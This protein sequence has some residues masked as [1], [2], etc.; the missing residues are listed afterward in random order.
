MDSLAQ[1]GIAIIPDD[2]CQVVVEPSGSSS[3]LSDQGSTT[4][5]QSNLFSR[6]RISSL[7]RTHRKSTPLDEHTVNR[8]RKGQSSR[9]HYSDRYL[10]LFKDTVAEIDSG[11]DGVSPVDP[12]PTQ[13][14]AVNWQ[15]SEKERLLHALAR[16]GRLDEP[17]IATLVGKSELE[18]R[19]Y[20]IFLRGKE[21]ERHLFERQT[22]QISQADI[23]AAVDISEECVSALEQAADALAMYQ[24]QYDLA[25]AEQQH[26]GT[27]LIDWNTAK[28]LDKQVLDQE[29]AGVGLE[30]LPTVEDVPCEGLFRLSSWLELSERL[31]MNSGPPRLDSNWR[32]I[33]TEDERPA[34]TFAAFADFHDLAVSITRRLMQTCMFL[35][36]SR[37]RST[38]SQ[39]HDPKPS[40]KEKDV[41]AA[42]EVLGMTSSLSDK[43]LG[44]ARRN[45][46]RV[47]RGSHDKGSR[48][49]QVLSYEEVEK[50]ISSRQ[51]SRRGRRSVSMASRSSGTPTTADG[52]ISDPEHHDPTSPRVSPSL[53]STETT[54]TDVSRSDV[55]MSDT[56]VY[57]G[58]SPEAVYNGLSFLA[59]TSQQK[60]RQICLERQQDA[61]MEDLDRL[62][63]EEEEK[64]LWQIL[65]RDPPT[66]VKKDAGE[67]LGARPKT[68]RKTQEDLADWQGMYA[69][70]W[71]AFGE[72]IP[73]QHFLR[74][75]IEKGSSTG[76]RLSSSKS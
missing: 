11:T 4:S 42:L 16:K 60:R 59:S 51:K 68:L 18:V 62:K 3:E 21:A 57:T 9:K 66:T 48:R 30:D 41:I 63:S 58:V 33:A 72:R 17:G 15:P 19:D 73:E 22:K 35:A 1:S 23:P 47:I 53:I 32:H 14:G 49:S 25:V 29:E 31:F 61:Y 69:S 34:L 36:E 76:E 20:L 75:G 65:G 28:A 71:E 24:D 55:S 8:K 39:H 52:A 46:L 27:W 74:P 70:E 2:P 5:D 40:V 10:E 6:G 12:R 13:L 50:E 43:L 37:M 45:S 38:Q 7:Q 44:V 56:E 26:P 54:E 64:R 67:H